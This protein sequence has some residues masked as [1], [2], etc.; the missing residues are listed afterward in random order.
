MGW[1]KVSCIYGVLVIRIYCGLHHL[2]P[3][4]FPPSLD[5][6]F[7][8][9]SIYGEY[10]SRYSFE[11]SVIILLDI[12]VLSWMVFLPWCSSQKVVIRG[13]VLGVEWVSAGNAP[14][15]IHSLLRLLAECIVI[16]GVPLSIH[17][18]FW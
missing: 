13:L 3:R 12:P 14:V 16:G 5:C 17:P 11:D 1:A 6:I 10:S 2:P 8:L 18:L 15:G 7:L 4:F 9:H